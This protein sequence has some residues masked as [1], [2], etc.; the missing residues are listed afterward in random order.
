M[1]EVQQTEEQSP[2]CPMCSGTT[3]LKETLQ[4]QNG[5]HYFFKCLVC[6]VEYPVVRLLGE[7][8]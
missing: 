4:H 8:R 3:A 7:R 1:S 2:P 6:A 5:M